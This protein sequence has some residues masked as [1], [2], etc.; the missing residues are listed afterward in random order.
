[1]MQK[2][3]VSCGSSFEI[4]S[5]DLR[6]LAKLSPEVGGKR[7]PIPPPT[8][9]IDCRQRRRL[10]FRNE[11]CLYRRPCD[12]CKREII[13]IYRTGTDYTVY[14]P[15]CF[16]S[17]QWD[18]LLF[19]RQ[20]D[21]QRPFFEQFQELQK[22]VPRIAL[23]VVNNENSDYINL[24]GYNKNCYLIFAAEYDEDCLYGCQIIKSRD[25][26]DTLCCFESEGCYEVVD[27]EKSYNLMFSRNCSNCSDGAFL[28][29]CKSCRNCLF[30]S[31]LRN[32][33]YCVNNEKVTPEEFA[34]KKIEVM[35]VL[36][37]G[38]RA[39]LDQQFKNI[40][41]GGIHRAL[42]LLNCEASTGNYLSHCKNC[43]HCFD[44]SY[45][46][47]CHAVFT[48]FHVKDLMDVCHTTEA[49]LGYEV[50]SLGYNSYHALFT[51]ASWTGRS[52]WYC[53]V[54]HSSS[55]I[56]GCAGL[57][58]KQYCIFNKQYTKEEYEKLV[59]EIIAH[60]QSTHE[61]GEFFPINLS[62]FAYN[63]TLA[64]EYYPLTQED[65]A[66]A[67]LPW[68]DRSDEKAEIVG[69]KTSSSVPSD[70]AKVRDDILATPLLCEATGRPYKIVKKELE[71]YRQRGLPIPRFHPD[72]R[73]RRRMAQRLPR[74][75]YDRTC[76]KCGSMI[77]TGISPGHA[78]RV[79]CEECY[80]KEI[81]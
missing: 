41:E 32:Q 70:S 31:N 13:S 26:I 33:E 44:L 65:A 28:V 59:G 6:F 30:G 71:F 10:T 74:R 57:R 47:D 79:F 64:Q 7:F 36:R 2:T 63:E 48:G 56:F 55:N 3:C 80:S 27:C 66:T 61:Y 11:R 67:R 24:S 81:Y 5:E 14:C 52:A 75:L 51:N 53:D 18:S 77:H 39:E 68:H 46:E 35:D 29:D 43:I 49:E 69:A 25:C 50:T 42:E 76:Q 22:A 16:W 62:P 78:E 21:F 8:H 60:M 4:T 23:H 17:D 34:K 9:C 73:H 1:M 54:I 20:V 19:G 38:N 45:G 15:E 40:A 12:L 58:S 72:E 37:N